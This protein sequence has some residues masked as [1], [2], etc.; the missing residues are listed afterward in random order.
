MFKPLVDYF[1]QIYYITALVYYSSRIE[2][3]WR[4]RHFVYEKKERP[5][6]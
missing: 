3:T 6:K 4:I 1:L 2:T 5:S